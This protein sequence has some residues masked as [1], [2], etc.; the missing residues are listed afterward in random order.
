MISLIYLLDYTKFGYNYKSLAIMA[1]LS[2]LS[3][4]S[5]IVEKNLVLVCVSILLSTIKRKSIELLTL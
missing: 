3:I 4:L 5:K 2:E 1:I